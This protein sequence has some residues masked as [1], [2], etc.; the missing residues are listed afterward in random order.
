MVAFRLA[1]ENSLFAVWLNGSQL[2]INKRFNLVQTS[3]K[4]YFGFAFLQNHNITITL[5]SVK[6]IQKGKPIFKVTFSEIAQA[7]Q[8]KV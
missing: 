4:L 3:F 8:A 5:V 6:P 7:A 1:A 2:T